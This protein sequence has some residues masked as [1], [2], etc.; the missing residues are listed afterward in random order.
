MKE[1]V[2][3]DFCTWHLSDMAGRADDVCCWG[4]SR[5]RNYKRRLP[6]M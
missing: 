2:Q 1:T 6:K 5:P 3:F 4:Q